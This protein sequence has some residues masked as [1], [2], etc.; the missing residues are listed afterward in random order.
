MVTY[1]GTLDPQYAT[2]L[3][4]VMSPD[5]DEDD[6]ELVLSGENKKI[7][8]SQKLFSSWPIC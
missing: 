7:V 6:I 2:E 1:L 5:S 4:E 8:W 3:A